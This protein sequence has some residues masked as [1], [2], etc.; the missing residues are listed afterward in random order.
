MAYIINRLR[1]EPLVWFLVAGVMLF[2]LHAVVSQG[3][4]DAASR[5][6]RVDRNGLLQFMQ[7]RARSFNDR[8]ATAMLGQMAPEEVSSLVDDMVREEAKYLEAL[9]LGLDKDDYVMR[10]R[11][12][13]SLEYVADGAGADQ[14]PQQEPALKHY[15]EA[16]RARY[17]AEPSITFS[18]I[19]F[20]A[21]A[22]GWDG[23]ER[24]ARQAQGGLNAGP[25]TS[26]ALAGDRYLYL[27]DY[28]ERNPDLI[29]SH[30]GKAFA[31]NLFTLKA[32]EKH[33]QGPLRSE[34]G[35]HLVR[36]VAK[37]EGR[38]LSFAE[39]KPMV[40]EDA[41]K[42]AAQGRRDAFVEALLKQFRVDV[43]RDVQK[44]MTPAK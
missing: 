40:A 38:S 21:D 43:S 11:L 28:S 30:F 4:D 34:Q 36:I 26:A 16:N 44:L 25:D 29:E 22:H 5:V 17:T 7:L 18:H 3:D 20:S 2:G 15:Y 39:A 1:R 10:R 8:G 42:D 23:A 31:R 41:A 13:Q 32:D 12:T 19:F 27:K 35:Y 6:I 14:P 33:W 37:D 9:R 24:M